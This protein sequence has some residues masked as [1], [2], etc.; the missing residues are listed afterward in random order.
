MFI[1]T[2]LTMKELSDYVT[3]IENDHHRWDFYQQDGCDDVKY[4]IDSRECL[5][6]FC[7]EHQ[8]LFIKIEKQFPKHKIGGSI[9]NGYRQH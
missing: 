8:T 7:E 1:R 2:D 3:S 4:I 9:S 5:D 6:Y